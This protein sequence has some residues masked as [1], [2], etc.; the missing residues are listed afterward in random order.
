[1]ASGYS[2]PK[3]S[4]DRQNQI[5]KKFATFPKVLLNQID[6][7]GKIITLNNSGSITL[8]L[9]V[10]TAGFNCM[11]IQSGAGVVTLTGSST[12]ISNKYSFTKTAGLNSVVT[13]IYLTTNT[14]IT[15]GDMSN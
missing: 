14:A 10:L 3:F 11:I 9:P 2:T 8:T 13:V 4:L 12:T 15:I 6:D 7:N 1:M 5:S